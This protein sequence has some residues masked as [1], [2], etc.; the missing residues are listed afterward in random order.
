MG[1]LALYLAFTG[2][3]ISIYTYYRAV[4]D[5]KFL[6]F[7]RRSL[8]ISSGGIILSAA[9]LMS[10]ILQHNFG[11]AYVWSYSDRNLPLHFLVSTFYAGQEGSFLFW[12]LCSSI[13]SFFVLR[14]T[15]TRNLEAH[16]L[17]IFVATQTF[18]VL[19][20]L[21]KSPFQMI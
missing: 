2:G 17:S 1:L 13:L 18:L 8:Y 6:R 7:G 16:V 19:L 3:V 12:A 14:Y 11:N 5:D 4:S 21:F 20:M 15:R 9:F 10:D